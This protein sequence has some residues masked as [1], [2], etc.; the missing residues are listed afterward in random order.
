VQQE[1][2]SYSPLLIVQSNR[3]LL[4]GFGE[5][6]LLHWGEGLLGLCKKY[7]KS[8]YEH[9]VDKWTKANFPDKMPQTT[10]LQLLDE[11]RAS[12]RDKWNKSAV[13]EFFTPQDNDRLAQC[14]TTY[15]EWFNKFYKDCETPQVTK[16]PQKRIIP[17]KKY[18]IFISS[19][20]I[21]FEEERKKIAHAISEMGHIPVG[22]ELF[23]AS[24][25]EQFNHIK[26]VI[27]V[28]DYVV[29]I[30]GGRYG[31]MDDFGISYT[32]KEYD[33]A[34]GKGLSVLAFINSD[35]VSLPADKRDFDN[36]IIQKL[37]AFRKKVKDR[38]GLCKMWQN[39]SDLHGL[40]VISLT[41]E[42]REHP[43]IGYKRADEK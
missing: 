4:S 9:S 42:I 16:Q 21:D 43:A 14:M 38:Q 12:E 5:Y 3:I 31:S 10:A 8:T 26:R 2:D 30:I 11:L 20:Y 41:N 13:A 36:D 39:P 15:F 24:T 7:T 28:S 23:P 34:V 37:D 22:M 33:Y 32:E 17:E 1:K 29:L 25:E 27:D 19:T 18:Q 6:V 35:P 40:A